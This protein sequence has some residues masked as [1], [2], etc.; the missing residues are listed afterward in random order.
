MGTTER[1]PGGTPGALSLEQL[2]EVFEPDT[3]APHPVSVHRALHVARHLQRRAMK[4][5]APSEKRQ[6]RELERMMEMPHDKATLMQMTDQA[7]RA[8]RPPR[9]ADQLIHLFDV[10]GIPRFFSTLDRA[11]L[12]GF[13]SFGRY[14][15][16]VAVPV[17]REKMRDETA[18][19]ILPAES[20]VLLPHLKAR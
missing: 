10:Q 9:A 6:Q 12:K 16:G 8:K 18:N 3:G 4:L 7:L 1:T 17:M 2:L 5:Q 15:P 19:V 20:D 11:L 13:Q 14:L